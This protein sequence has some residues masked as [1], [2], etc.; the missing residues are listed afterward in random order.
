[1]YSGEIEECTVGK[2]KNVQWGNSRMCSGEIEECTV[3]KFK[4][5]QWGN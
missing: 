5:V 1:M 4:N 3:G 2:F